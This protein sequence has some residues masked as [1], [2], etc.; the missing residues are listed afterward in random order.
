MRPFSMTGVRAGLAALWLY[1]HLISPLKPPCCRFY[2]SCSAYAREAIVRF[3]LVRGSGLAVWR[4]LRCHPLYRGPLY[5]PVP[6]GTKPPSR[7]VRT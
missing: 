4:L 6:G 2:P 3:G 1:R 5:D 7:G